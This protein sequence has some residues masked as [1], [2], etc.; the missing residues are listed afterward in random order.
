T[1]EI[2]AATG[3]FTR[4]AEPERSRQAKIY[5]DGTGAAAEVP[6][7]RR[8]AG[9]WVGVQESVHRPDDAG[10]VGIACD[11]RPRPK[12][13]ISENIGSGSDTE[14][15]AGFDHDDRR[16]PEVP[17]GGVGAAVVRPVMD[18]VR[19]GAVF[20]RHAVLI[21]GEGSRT[22]RIAASTAEH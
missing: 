15:R 11:S 14:R 22:V 9:L 4:R 19:G 7:K 5:R 10:L 13:L 3:A 1:G 17:L 21:G 20:A 18:V 12:Q 8:L 6:R 16:R 2:T